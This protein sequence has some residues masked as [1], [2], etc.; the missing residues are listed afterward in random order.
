VWGRI[1]STDAALLGQRLDAM[2]RMVCEDDPRTLPQRRAD[3]LGALA[4]GSTQLSCQCGRSDCPAVV[5]DG[6]ASSIVVHL[7]AEQESAQAKSDARLHGEG[8][9]PEGAQDAEGRK[10]AALIFGRG[11]VPAPLLSELITRG[12]K[13]RPVVA[14]KPE[15]EPHYRPS[16]SLDEFV[17]VR[18]MT[19]RAAGCDRLATH[20]DI[21]HTVAY[22]AGATHPGNLKC[23]CRIHHLLKLSMADGPIGNCPTA[24][25]FLRDRALT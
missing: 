23:Y 17:R 12:A 25:K 24:R 2:A 3:A 4:A 22:P 8:S 19:C 5:D 18:D 21:D 1:F 9:A 6:R 10:K 7:V 14:P 16:T 13:L 11:I 20:A 15:P